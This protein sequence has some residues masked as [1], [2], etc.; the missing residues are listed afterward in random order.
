MRKSPLLNL[1]K[2]KDNAPARDSGDLLGTM[3][4]YFKVF[5]LHFSA[6]WHRFMWVEWRMYVG[7]NPKN[8]INN[9]ILEISDMEK[10]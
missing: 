7:G 8:K 6:A 3:D 5:Q 2:L 10:I 1:E 9:Y 4:F